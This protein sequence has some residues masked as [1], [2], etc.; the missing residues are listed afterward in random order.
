MIPHVTQ[1]LLLYNVFCSLGLYAQQIRIWV[2][3]NCET[4]SPLGLFTQKQSFA[5][6]EVVLSTLQDNRSNES[7]SVVCLSDMQ[8]LNCSI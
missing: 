1:V 4:C 2:Q 8:G 7:D 5:R 6:I 3:K